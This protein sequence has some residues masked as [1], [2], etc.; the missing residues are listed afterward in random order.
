MDFITSEQYVTFKALEN[1]TC[2]EITVINDNTTELAETF[3]INFMIPE[4]QAPRGTSN[5][6]ATITIIDDDQETANG[7]IMTTE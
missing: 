6:S 7:M 3:S 1:K 4:T 2:T 5:T